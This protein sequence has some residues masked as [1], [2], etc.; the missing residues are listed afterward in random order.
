MRV[1]VVAPIGKLGNVFPHVFCRNVDVSAAHRALEMSPL[2][3]NRVRM[4]DASNPLLFAVV[5]AAK[6]ETVF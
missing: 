2:S 1:A 6:I 3:F 4:V 5:D